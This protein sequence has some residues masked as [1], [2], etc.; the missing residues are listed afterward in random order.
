MK[1]GILLLAKQR[2]LTS[3]SSLWA[4]KRALETKKIGHTG[5]LD[6]FADGLLVVLSGKMT[7]LVSHI[8]DFDKTY[9]ALIRFGTETDTLDPE[10]AVIGSA[11]LPDEKRFREAVSG[12]TG[13]QLQFPPAYSALRVN[14]RRS[15]DMVRSGEQVELCPRPVTIHSIDILSFSGEYARI[16]VSCS[17]GTYIRSLARDIALACGS[18]GHL[19]ALRRTSVGPFRLE[20]AV[21]AGL[22]P[23]ADVVVG[24]A[25]EEISG[26]EISPHQIR[27][28]LLRFTPELALR[29]G[30][31]PA[32]LDPSR[33]SQFRNGQKI[34]PQWFSPLCGDSWGN[35]DLS[36][37]SVP[38]KAAGLALRSLAVFSAEDGSLCFAG[39]V[40]HRQGGPSLSAGFDYGFVL[41]EEE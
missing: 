36:E 6:T 1:S 30:F 25:S 41:G 5:T 9:D 11:P 40:H 34:L 12:F 28:G 32:L 26:E 14:G 21:G 8:T 16:R 31:E 24:S 15:S 3:F 29:C 20:D 23:P 13:G 19:A 33:R 4:V 2:G 39:I 18:R 27:A 7:R 22:L 38:G 17:K 37:S 10:G 35:S